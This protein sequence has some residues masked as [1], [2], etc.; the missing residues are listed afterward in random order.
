MGI[1]R[2][3]AALLLAASVLAI[4]LTGAG[5]L[6]RLASNALEGLLPRVTAGA[7]E[8]DRPI[9]ECGGM[10]C[11][12]ES[13]DG[14]G[15]R[16]TGARQAVLRADDK[17]GSEPEHPQIL[18][19]RLESG[20]GAGRGDPLEYGQQW[21]LGWAPEEHSAHRRW[22]AGLLSLASVVAKVVPAPRR[23]YWWFRSTLSPP[24][25]ASRLGPSSS[26]AQR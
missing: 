26:G 16:R 24:S 20:V 17:D 12:L 10:D 19:G 23:S 11:S 13:A 18:A 3:L 4:W 5:A 15:S 1:R 25:A 21:R 14:G 6:P 7:L 22:R 8:A 9:V 2:W